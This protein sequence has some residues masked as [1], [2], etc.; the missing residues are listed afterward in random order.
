M[1]TLPHDLS[2]AAGGRNVTLGPEQDLLQIR[3]I[4]SKIG[5]GMRALQCRVSH[6][7][8]LQ[9]ACRCR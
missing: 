7:F 5:P 1:E 3:C 9:K 8:R 6:P 2:D 4:S